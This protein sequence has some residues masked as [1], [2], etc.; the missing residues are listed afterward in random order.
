MLLQDVDFWDKMSSSL[1]R[2]GME[3]CYFYIWFCEF[4]AREAVSF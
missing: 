4:S 2:L 3:N 1:V